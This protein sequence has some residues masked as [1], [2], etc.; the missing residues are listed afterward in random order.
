MSIAT[1]S[2]KTFGTGNGVTTAFTFSF[3]TPDTASISVTYVN[4]SNVA[5]D[6]TSSCTIVLN[7][8]PAGGLWALGGTVTYTPGG[9]P[10]ATGTYITIV[11][12][13]TEDQDTAFANQDSVYNQVTE[14]TF[15]E[16]V[17]MIQ[18]LQEVIDRCIKI[19]QTDQTGTSV[20]LLAAALRA[21]ATLVTDAAGNVTTG[22]ATS[23]TISS[24][25][26]PVVQA[27]TLAAA[28]TA[29]GVITD[30]TTTEGDVIYRHSSA[31]TRLA[32]GAA[33]TMLTSNGTD[34]A[35]TTLTATLDALFSSTQGA[36]LYRGAATWAALAPGT[37]GQFLATGGAAANPSWTSP[38]SSSTPAVPQGRLT[39]ASGTP[40]MTTTQSAKTSIFYTPYNGAYAPIY[41]GSMFVNNTFAELTLA[42]DS[43]SGH[44]GYQQSGKLFDLFVFLNSSTVTLCTG[45]AWTSGTGRG[46]GAGTTELQLLSGIWTNKNTLTAKIDATSSTVSV[47]AN[48]ATYL[49]TMLASAD[50]TT[51]FVYGALAAGGT[52]AAFNLWNC[53]NRILVQTFVQDSTDSYN[54]S[55]ATWRSANGSATMRVSFI[56][57]LAEDGFEAKYLAYSLHNAVGALA[58]RFNG[59]GYDST[60]AL[61]SGC[62]S[63]RADL[64]TV[65]VDGVG[66]VGTPIS[67][68]FAMFSK[69]ADLGSHFCQA[70]EYGNASSTNTWYGDNGA[71]TTQQTG[72]YFSGRF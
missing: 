33:N 51:Q 5:T 55:L 57:G 21:S 7:A 46:A 69:A 15:D 45:P 32:I 49:G 63:G 58:A 13:L 56:Q 54:Y 52:A 40:V 65:A 24:A 3:A 72:L 27:L 30:P 67:P 35:W 22:S 43:N 14:M 66:S 37:A 18:Q 6:V 26:I 59:I 28:R 29:L 17:M 12:T 44:T 31:L 34:P 41:N 10:I 53:Y 42:L 11:R 68:M 62:A 8:V 4:A 61:A 70:L 47:T 16:V 64:A 50:G 39:L 23:T 1:T 25:M 71:P 38:A 60:S 48:Q 2:N 9:N 19:P 36:V 20:T